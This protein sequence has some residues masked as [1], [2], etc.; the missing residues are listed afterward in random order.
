MCADATKTLPRAKTFIMPL[1]SPSLSLSLFCYAMAPFT[2]WLEMAKWR[3]DEVGG[4]VLILKRTA[5]TL[6]I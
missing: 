1:C 4:I 6:A 5:G 3:V 2:S